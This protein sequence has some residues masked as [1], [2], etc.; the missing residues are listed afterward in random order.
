MRED[1]DV[2]STQTWM[3]ISWLML[4]SDAQYWSVRTSAD[5][6]YDQRNLP[7]LTLMPGLKMNKSLP[8]PTGIPKEW[9]AKPVTKKRE[10]EQVRER[11]GQEKE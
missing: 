2:V 5:D 1:K 4:G 6:L 8:T 7:K 9:R 3:T 10:Q 11:D